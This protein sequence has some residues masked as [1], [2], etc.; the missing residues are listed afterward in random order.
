VIADTS[1]PAIES[2]DAVQR[3]RCTIAMH[4]MAEAAGA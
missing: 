1:D 2:A 4:L 3:D